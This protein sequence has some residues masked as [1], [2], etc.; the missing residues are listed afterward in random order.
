MLVSAC[1]LWD[2]FRSH[3]RAVLARA[4]PSDD[5]RLKRR[6]L[7]WIRA[8]GADRISREEVRREALGQAQNAHQ[9]LLVLRA[10]ERA[11][12]LRQIAYQPD[13]AGRP[14]LRWDV[15]PLLIGTSPAEIAEIIIPSEA[16]QGAA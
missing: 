16:A 15:N 10:L 7:D 11:G 1:S 2:Y 13:G 9:S 8:R 12:Y 3:A 14:P 6:V 4:F 5:V